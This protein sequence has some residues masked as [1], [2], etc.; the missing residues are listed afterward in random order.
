M[1]FL[2]THKKTK[3]TPHIFANAPLTLTSSNRHTLLQKLFVT[4]T[5]NHIS[6]RSEEDHLHSLQSDSHAELLKCFNCMHLLSYIQDKNIVI[7][8]LNKII[9]EHIILLWYSDMW[10]MCVWQ[11]YHELQLQLQMHLMPHDQFCVWWCLPLWIVLE[12]ITH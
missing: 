6:F 7:W 10:L 1:Q 4:I 12:Q 11:N 2:R 3:F 8:D 9:Q 5:S